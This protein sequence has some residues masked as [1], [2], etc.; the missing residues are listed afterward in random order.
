MKIRAV[1]VGDTAEWQR[2]R[3]TLWDDSLDEHP[4]EIQAFFE[5]RNSD[6]ETFVCE[7]GNGKLGGFVEVGVRKYAEGCDSDRVGY[8]EGLYVDQDLRRQGIASQLIQAAEDWARS[9]EIWEMASDCLIDNH[10]SLAMHLANGFE[11][12]ERI[13]CFRKTLSNG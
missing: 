13:I 5:Q 7:R 12:V 2:M 10:V 4:R 6:L 9:H 11:E 8:I 3:A 1:T